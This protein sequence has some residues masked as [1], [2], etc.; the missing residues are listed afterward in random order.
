MATEV[1]NDEPVLMLDDK[2]YVVSEMSDEAKY[3]VS[4]LQNIQGKQNQ[5]RM[6]MD[7]LTIAAEGFTS[8]LKAELEKPEDSEETSE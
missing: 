8:R 6:E 2:K 4:A 5:H 7:T 1:T 3:M